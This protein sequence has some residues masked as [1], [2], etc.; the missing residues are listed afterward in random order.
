[1]KVSELL[2]SIKPL[3]EIPISNFFP[4]MNM[5]L[6]EIYTFSI[7]WDA[8]LWDFM[9][10]REAFSVSS[11]W[12]DETLQTKYPILQVHSFYCGKL[13]VEKRFEA[14]KTNCSCSTC[15][16]LSPLPDCSC[17]CESIDYCPCDNKCWS[18]DLVPTSSKWLLCDNH[19]QI[20]WGECWFGWFWWQMLRV[21][22]GKEYCKCWWDGLWVE[23]YGWFN[24]VKC[25]DNDFPL[26]RHFMFAFMYIFQSLLVL[27]SDPEMSAI[28]YQRYINKIKSLASFEWNTLYSIKYGN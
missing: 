18:L 23:Y 9:L 3:L 22:V 2:S 20:V 17:W 19:Y 11:W 12:I 24:P 26:P 6:S 1:M 21:K 25:L 14:N 10:K 28:M 5:A 15:N 8:M 4:I 16:C 27:K 13:P 7:D